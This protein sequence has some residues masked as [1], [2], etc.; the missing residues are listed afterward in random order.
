M[1]PALA[2]ELPDDR[3]VARNDCHTVVVPLPKLVYPGIEFGGAQF[4]VITTTCR[5]HTLDAIATSLEAVESMLGPQY[6]PALCYY[7]VLAGR[8][9]F[10][11][12]TPER[13]LTDLQ[14]GESIAATLPRSDSTSTSA[15]GTSHTLGA[16]VWPTMYGTFYLTARRGDT[17]EG[18]SV[19]YGLLQHGTP[20]DTT[21]IM[22]FFNAI[23]DDPPTHMEPWPLRQLSLSSD[24]RT[25][26]PRLEP[27]EDAVVTPTSNQAMQLTHCGS[28]PVYGVPADDVGIATDDPELD[29]YGSSLQSISTLGYDM[30]T[31]PE[32]EANALDA[33]HALDTPVDGPCIVTATLRRE[34]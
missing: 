14:N 15:G 23:T 29:I 19:T 10:I 18:F 8:C 24:G 34:R 25:P 12:N 6:E 21:P 17:T 13:F 20:L 11:S 33:I 31:N 27:I 3:L 28:N 22:Q 1:D 16:C 5:D 30:A 4:S 9:Q 26:L 7:G 2:D 32:P